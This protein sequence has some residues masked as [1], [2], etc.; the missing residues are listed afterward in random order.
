MKKLQALT[1]Y[2]IERR[3]VMPEQL[4]SWANQISLELIWNRSHWTARSGPNQR[5]NAG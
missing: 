4:D 3:L 2:L 5:R 1:R